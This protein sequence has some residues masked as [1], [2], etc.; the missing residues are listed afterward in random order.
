MGPPPI[1][2][3]IDRALSRTIEQR[4]VLSYGVLGSQARNWWYYGEDPVANERCVA[5]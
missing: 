4:L 5:L 1:D 3:H 2:Q